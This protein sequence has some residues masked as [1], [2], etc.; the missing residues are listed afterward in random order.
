MPEHMGDISHSNH[1]ATVQFVFLMTTSQTFVKT[2]KSYYIRCHILRK[3][4]A[5]PRTYHLSVWGQPGSSECFCVCQTHPLLVYAYLTPPLSSQNSFL[6]YQ[7]WQVSLYFT[8][9]WTAMTKKI[10]ISKCWQR[11]RETETLSSESFGTHCGSG[12]LQMINTE[13]PVSAH[14]RN[15]SVCPHQILS[16]QNHQ[17]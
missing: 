12:V 3:S 15:E 1:Y 14:R 10:G 9:G 11:Y 8:G 2:H 13:L 6:D 4:K 5:H 17:H 7:N 16:M